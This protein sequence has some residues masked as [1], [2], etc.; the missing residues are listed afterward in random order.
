MLFNRRKSKNNTENENQDDRQ[1]YGPAKS[2]NELGNLGYTLNGYYLV[3]G[4]DKS[5]RIGVEVVFCRF[6]Q[7]QGVKESKSKFNYYKNEYLKIHS[8]II[9]IDEKA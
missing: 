1:F 8:L 5:E 3:N 9:I 4:K 2:C 7:P 6:K